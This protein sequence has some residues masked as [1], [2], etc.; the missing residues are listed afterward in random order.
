MN[1]IVYSKD[2]CSFCVKAKML[3]KQ[4]RIGFV[5]RK[6]DTQNSEDIERAKVEMGRE[7]KTLPQ[8]FINDEYVGGFSDLAK[9]L[10]ITHFD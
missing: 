3:L 2:N 7:F 10:G 4:K 6:I 8:I 5:E 9:Y 1:A